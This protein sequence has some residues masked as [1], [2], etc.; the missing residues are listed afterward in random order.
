[1]YSEFSLVNLYLV[2][3]LTTDLIFKSW[4][5]WIFP[6]FFIAFQ[7]VFLKVFLVR[8]EFTAKCMQVFAAKTFYIDTFEYYTRLH[9]LK[10]SQ[11]FGWMSCYTII[12][13]VLIV[14]WSGM[15][16]IF[17]EVFDLFWIYFNRIDREHE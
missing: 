13:T 15:T 11:H 1:M 16:S 8:I 14:T 9:I 5:F 3:N 12:I 17:R 7:T 4:W 6:I 10:T 2:F